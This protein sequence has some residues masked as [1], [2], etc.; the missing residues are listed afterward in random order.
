[1]K[2]F[3]SLIILSVLLVFFTAPHASAT[4]YSDVPQSHPHFVAINY[5]SDAGVLQG[6]EGGLFKPDQ[7]INRVEVLKVI[8]VHAGVKF[9]EDGPDQVFSDVAKN[10]WFGLIVATAKGLGIVNG[11]PDGS[12]TPATN[13]RRAEFMKMMLETNHFKKTQW[14]DQQ[15]F[16]D[17]PKEE[18]HAPYMNYAGKSGLINTD[19]NGKLYPSKELTRDE[20]AEMLYLMRVIL[21]GGDTQFLLSQGEAQM[22]QIETYISAKNVAAA[23]RAAELALNMTQKAVLNV[24]NNTVALGAEKLADSYNLLVDS[25][26]AAT[27]KDKEKATS[28]AN[29]SKEMATTA[30][31]I[32]NDIQLLARHIKDRA[33]E[34]LAQL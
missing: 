8:L 26:I 34:I 12:F 17:V 21:K 16:T 5:L 25:Y 27:Q 14:A 31:E 29:Q 3:F 30:W 11:H 6:Y 20:V 2:R 4:S 23:K 33:D 19:S 15:L 32:N 13:V 9:L 22:A 24:P 18:W 1:M 7:L 10:Q 28:L